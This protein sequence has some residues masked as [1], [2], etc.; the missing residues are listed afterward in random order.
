MSW[1]IIAIFLAL[2]VASLLKERIAAPEA[3]RSAWIVFC[4]L[5]LSQMIFAMMRGGNLQSTKDLAEI[6]L[7]ESGIQ[8]MI[9]AACVFQIANAMIPSNPRP[10]I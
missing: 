7:W 8:G 10:A 5:P 1:L 2:F 6:A 9:V 4:L 3:L